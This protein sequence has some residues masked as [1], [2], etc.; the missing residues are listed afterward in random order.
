MK[1]KY[2]AIIAGICLASCSGR[3]AGERELTLDKAGSGTTVHENNPTA[4][5]SEYYT[6]PPADSKIIREGY[7]VM[8]AKDYRSAME[9]IKLLVPSL[10]GYLVKENETTSGDLLQ[11]DLL[12]RVPSNKFDTLLNSV[13]KLASQVHSKSIEARDVTEEYV[14]IEARLKAK[15]EVEKRYLEILKQART[16]EDILKVE[17]QLRMIREEI[18]AKEGRMK[19]LQNQS[20]YSTL[21]LILQKKLPVRLH[22]DFQFKLFNALR[23]GWRGFLQFAI[24]L[25]YLWPFL[26]IGFAGFWFYRNRRKR[27]HDSNRP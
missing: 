16:V 19:Y 9:Q 26:L 22:F 18:E 8:E 2:I 13:L 20:D 21:N 6:S 17:E 23:G 27:N 4:N 5:K 15:Q 24:L 3:P 10:N 1:Y 11:N 7:L 25:V 12:L 14:D